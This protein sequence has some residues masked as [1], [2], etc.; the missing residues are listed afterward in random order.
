MF[1]QSERQGVIM[2]GYEYVLGKTYKISAKNT[3]FDNS[4]T[5]NQM[6]VFQIKIMFLTANLVAK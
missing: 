1:V 6:H 4:L 5:L 2:K 3:T